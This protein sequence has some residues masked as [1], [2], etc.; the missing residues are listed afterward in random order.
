MSGQLGCGQQHA[1]AECCIIPLPE[2]CAAD[3][4][5]DV[6]TSSASSGTSMDRVSMT[7]PGRALA[8]ALPPVG[9]LHRWMQTS[10]IKQHDL[11]T[12]K[13]HAG[14]AAAWQG[15][16]TCTHQWQPQSIAAVQVG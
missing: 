9:C 3:G 5:R 15:H 4:S 14:S 11:P 2:C 1:Q 10:Y 7:C 13:L 16:M 6:H 12:S 8:A